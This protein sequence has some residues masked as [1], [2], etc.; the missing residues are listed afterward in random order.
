LVEKSKFDEGEIKCLELIC[1]AL[2]IDFTA[3]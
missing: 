3:S 1:D 2:C